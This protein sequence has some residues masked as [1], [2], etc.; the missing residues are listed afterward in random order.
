MKLKKFLF[1]ILV[2]C[3]LFVAGTIKVNATHYLAC[4]YQGGTNGENDFNT[5]IGYKLGVFFV[6]GKFRGA[7]TNNPKCKKGCDAGTFYGIDE[8]ELKTAVMDYD[9]ID[10]NGSSCPQISVIHYLCWNAPE[11]QNRLNND[12][13]GCYSGIPALKLKEYNHFVGDVEDKTCTYLDSKTNNTVTLDVNFASH[14][15]HWGKE[16]SDWPHA[17]YG[18]DFH[19]TTKGDGDVHWLHTN[20]SDGNK[21]TASVSTRAINFLTSTKGNCPYYLSYKSPKKYTLSNA[22]YGSYTMYS[23]TCRFASDANYKEVKEFF[24][25]NVNGANVTATMNAEFGKKLVSAIKKYKDLFSK[26]NQSDKKVCLSDTNFDDA[27]TALCSACLGDESCKSSEVEEAC[28]SIESV[29]NSV[30]ATAQGLRDMIENIFPDG[31]GPGTEAFDCDGVFGSESDHTSLMYIIVRVF[32]WIRVAVPIIL[33]ILGIVDF[34]K[35]V[36]SQDADAMKKA[37]SAFSKR[38]V[39]ALLVFFVPWLLTILLRW[40][41]DYIISTDPTCVT[42]NLLSYIV[43]MFIK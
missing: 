24:T 5:S 20:G 33:L 17:K 34:S 43:M 25:S 35:V 16:H 6:D 37:V 23:L 26:M 27:S 2:A 12:S 39:M 31:L 42:G 9:S 4:Q 19:G 7:Y 38:C 40:I 36:I 21:N 22:N 1:Y 18:I 28:G 10:W 11:G 32:T 14:P 29:N 30:G 13:A 41:N 3:T 8:T 15:I